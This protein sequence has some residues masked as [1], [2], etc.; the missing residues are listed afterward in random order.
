MKKLIDQIAKFGV[1]GVVCFFIDW[2]IYNIF[3]FIFRKCGIADSFPEYYL[4]SK[5]IAF[6]VSMVS[7]Y[8]LS[9]KF[10]FVRRDDMSRKKEFVIFVILSTIGLLIN[11]ICLFI[12]MDLIYGNWKF[13][14]KL[15]NRTVAENFFM[16]GATGVVMVYNFVSRK[17]FLEKKD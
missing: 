17:K 6:V 14:Q 15:M 9:M 12:G 3:N 7:N 8:L 1:V 4:V 13:L 10:V 16:I 2:G 5:A 11:E